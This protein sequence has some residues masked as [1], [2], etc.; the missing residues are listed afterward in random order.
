MS[1]FETGCHAL[2]LVI[3]VADMLIVLAVATALSNEHPR[4]SAVVAALSG[5]WVPPW[6]AALF[7]LCGINQ[8]A[9]LFVVSAVWGC[10]WTA[11][12]PI[13]VFVCAGVINRMRPAEDTPDPET[14]TRSIVSPPIIDAQCCVCHENPALP[15]TLF[16]C[17]HAFVCAEDFPSAIAHGLTRCP[18]C[19]GERLK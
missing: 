3:C 5:L 11:I 13:F 8:P 1:F 18:F 4:R 19:R 15:A 16:E 2:V 14:P 9:V 6:W 12:A 17:G 7:A 10:I